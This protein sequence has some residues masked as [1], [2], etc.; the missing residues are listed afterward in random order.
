[1]NPRHLLRTLAFITLTAGTCLSGTTATPA[2]AGH[3]ATSTAPL[4]NGET[5]RYDDRLKITF[6]GVANDSRC[7]IGV[8]CISPGD[9][10][11]ILR[12]KEG[13]LPAKNYRLHTN[14]NPRHLIIPAN[15][16]LP[17]SVSVQKHY[18]IKIESLTP[19]RTIGVKKIRPCDYQV[20]LRIRA[21]L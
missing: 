2:A 12:I 18:E 3:A 5:L 21:S 20:S 10:E 14:N 9:A 19:F 13:T 4:H 16:P 8:F 1:M 11:I 7:P 15:D 6:L 17:S